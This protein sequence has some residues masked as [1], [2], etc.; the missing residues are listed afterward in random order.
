LQKVVE[1]VPDFTKKINVGSM[2]HSEGKTA[3]S[4]TVSVS[5]HDVAAYKYFKE[6]GIAATIQKVPSDGETD[7]YSLLTKKGFNV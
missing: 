6:K 1:A 5:D 4:Q 3:I 7:I 2:A